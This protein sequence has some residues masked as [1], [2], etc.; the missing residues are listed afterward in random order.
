MQLD[1]LRRQLQY[2]VAEE[3]DTR[4]ELKTL[5]NEY[6]SEKLT[7]QKKIVELD[8]KLAFVEANLNEWKEK[9]LDSTSQLRTVTR[10]SNLKVRQCF[11]CEHTLVL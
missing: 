8:S 10:Q 2:A 3:E 11:V 4:K 5:T 9:A 1:Q 7:L 6:S